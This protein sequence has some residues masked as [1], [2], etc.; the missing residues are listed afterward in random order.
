M[1]TLENGTPLNVFLPETVTMKVIST[2]SSLGDT[3]SG[4]PAVLEGGL[5]LVVPNYI[6]TNDAVVIHVREKRFLSRESGGRSF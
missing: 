3:Q 5:K 2:D 6:N 4:K 1:K